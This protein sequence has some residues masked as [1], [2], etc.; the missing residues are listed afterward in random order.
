MIRKRMI[1]LV[2]LS[3]TGLPAP[4]QDAAL[5]VEVPPSSTKIYYSGR[6]DTRD[7]SG[8]RCAWPATAALLRFEGNSV[9]VKLNENSSGQGPGGGN[10]YEIVVDGKP[11]MVI[12]PRPGEGTYRLASNLKAG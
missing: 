11:A 9:N 4:A 7:S 1:L 2:L 5:P 6:F 10:R 8:P 3:T 12:V